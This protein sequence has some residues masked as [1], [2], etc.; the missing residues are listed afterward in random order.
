[1]NETKRRGRK[2][3]SL[4]ECTRTFLQQMNR[5]FP[6]GCDCDSTVFIIASDGKHISSMFGGDD[7][8]MKSM[9]SYVTVKDD[10]V[11]NVVGEGLL[12]TIQLIK[13]AAHGEPV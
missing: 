4:Y 2:K 8:T 3:K 6:D 11:R 13:A 10:E 5:K 1:M 9:I 12:S 7:D